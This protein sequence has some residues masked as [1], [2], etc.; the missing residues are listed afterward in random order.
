MNR[1]TKRRIVMIEDEADILEVVAYRLE[2]EGFEVSTSRDGE[3]GL[4]RIRRERPDLVILDLMLPGMDGTEICRA[5]KRDPGTRD[6]PII[7]VTAKTEESDVVLGLGLGADDYVPKPFSPRELVARVQAVL[8]RAPVREPEVVKK[9]LS[10]GPLVIDTERHEALLDGEPLV[11]TATE[12]RLLHVLAAR[13]GRVY[14]RDELLSLAVGDDVV[15]GERNIDVHVRAIRQKL[16]AWRDLIETV[17]GVG[18]RFQG[19][20]E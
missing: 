7:M 11:L 8:R 4:A 10:R 9:R 20:R 15:V 3:E 6:I 14:S 13:P 19:S 5:V 16:G 18:Y 12:L 1:T 17:R 2:R